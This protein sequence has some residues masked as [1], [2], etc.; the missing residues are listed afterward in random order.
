MPDP[1]CRP[2]PP[3]FDGVFSRLLAERGV[4]LSKFR[5][6][7]ISQAYFASF[8]RQCAVLPEDM[9]WKREEDGLFPGKVALRLRFFLP[10]GSYAT[11]L[12]KSAGKVQEPRT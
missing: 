8:P 7:E 3:D 5:L 12:L 11:M 2:F 9:E 1:I 10:R 6:K 4:R